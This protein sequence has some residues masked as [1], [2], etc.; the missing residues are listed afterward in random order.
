MDGEIPDFAYG[1]AG[2]GKDL[3]W[4]Q[5]RAVDKNIVAIV[6]GDQQE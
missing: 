1:I 4:N 2:A 3:R 6:D 5:R